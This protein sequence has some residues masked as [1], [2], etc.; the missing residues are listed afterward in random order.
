MAYGFPNISFIGY[1]TSVP[2]AAHAGLGFRTAGPAD[3]PALL[4]HLRSLTPHD[5]RMRFCATLSDSAL[6]RHLAAVWARGSLVL[7]A[8]DGPLWSGPFHAAGP[9]RAAAEFAIDG[10]GSEIGLSVDPLMRRRGVGTYLLQT[11]ARLLAPRGVRRI[12]AMTS[13]ENIAFAALARACEAVTERGEDEIFHA[14]DVQALCRAYLLRRAAQVFRHCDGV[15]SRGTA[16]G[17]RCTDPI[18]AAWRSPKPAT[19]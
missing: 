16:S 17:K 5:R 3:S 8:H 11:G 18:H 1:P 15:G 10:S 9:I 2:C 13:P 4:A 12:V 19:R 14:F 7:A 6:E